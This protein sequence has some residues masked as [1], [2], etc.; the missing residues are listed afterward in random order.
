ML[1][2]NVQRNQFEQ[3]YRQNVEEGQTKL[4]ECA[5][6]CWNKMPALE[7][8]EQNKAQLFST[9]RKVLS[10]LPWIGSLMLVL[11]T[12]KIGMEED[13][14]VKDSMSSNAHMCL[15]DQI[16][17]QQVVRNRSNIRVNIKMLSVIRYAATSLLPFPVMMVAGVALGTFSTIPIGF[18]ILALAFTLWA[19]A[20]E[21]KIVEIGKDLLDF[22]KGVGATDHI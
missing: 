10:C 15:A 18:S 1:P 3:Q 2:P 5:S 13:K 22:K 14:I 7:T 9:T 17:P 8:T 12:I 4:N 21:K 16:L 6:N 20:E 11:N 19:L